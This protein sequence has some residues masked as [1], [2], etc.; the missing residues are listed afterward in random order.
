MGKK[1]APKAPDPRQ[2]AAASTSTNIG[3]AIANAMLNN[4]DYVGPDGSTT[5]PLRLA[6]NSLVSW[7][8]APVSMMAKRALSASTST[9]RLT[10]RLPRSEGLRP[11]WSPQ[12]RL[13]HHPV[14]R[15]TFP[16][17]CKDSQG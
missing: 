5:M 9:L 6:A 7:T 13:A 2:T 11:I 4:P 14:G 3:T 12:L 15:Q 1:S 16:I 17:I 10:S 8:L